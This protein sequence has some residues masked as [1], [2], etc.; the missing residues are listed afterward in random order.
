MIFTARGDLIVSKVYKASVKKTIADIFRIQVINNA[1][2]RSPMLTLGSTTFHFIRSVGDG[3]WL[4]AVSRNNADS[5]AIWEYLYQLEELMDMYG[6]TYE[7][8]LKDEFIVCHELLDITLGINGLPTD[9]AT[10]SVLKKMTVKPSQLIS[11]SKRTELAATSSANGHVPTNTITMPK[12]LSRH[13][14]RSVSREMDYK[15]PVPSSVPWRAGD[16]FYKKNDLIVYVSE[17]VSVLIDKDGKLLR[18]YV[19][20]TLD[21]MAQLSGVPV[22]QIGMNDSLTVQAG[23]KAMWHREDHATNVNAMPNSNQPTVKLED[24]KFH[25]CVSLEKF[26]D[27]HV[28]SFI[29]PDGQFDLMKY[30]VRDN[31]NLPFRVSPRVQITSD[32]SVMEYRITITALF[33]AKLFAQDVELRIPVPPETLDC[34][35]NTSDGRCRYLPAENCMLWNFNKFNGATEQHLDA[36]TVPS[37]T[38][39]KLGLQQWTRPSMSLGFMVDS[40]SSSGIV[41]H[42]I[43]VNE[44]H[45]NY[46]AN[47]WIKYLTMS[48]TYE[49][50][51]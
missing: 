37:Q 34:R 9:T 41:V 10:G 15:E 40:F 17:R 35:I 28:I 21:L 26:N 8:I 39:T 24:C 22:C 48:G 16:I 7:N 32:G 43:K 47:K 45:L 44:N 49:I 12:F 2:I 33:S 13:G 51:Y 23:D 27:D 4:V 25:H 30:H 36:F 29:P 1:E 38:S 50:R 6:L 46:A 31:L 14:Q 42:N 18:A 11:N 3:L 5:G 20:G 19:T